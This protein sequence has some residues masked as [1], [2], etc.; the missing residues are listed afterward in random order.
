MICGLRLWHNLTVDNFYF[1]LSIKGK[2]KEGILCLFPRL[3]LKPQ[4]CRILG[5]CS[6]GLVG[7]A[8][9]YSALISR[10]IVMLACSQVTRKLMI[11]SA[12]WTRRIWAVAGLMST[13]QRRYRIRRCGLAGAL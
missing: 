13:V 10:L 1:P 12:I 9:G 2:P 7:D 6:F 4:A 11:S 8:G 5:D 3:I